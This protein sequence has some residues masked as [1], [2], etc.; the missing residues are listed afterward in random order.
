MKHIKEMPVFERPFKIPRQSESRFFVSN[1]RKTVCMSYFWT[2]AAKSICTSLLNRRDAPNIA[3]NKMATIP[4][5]SEK[6]RLFINLNTPPSIPSCI[7]IT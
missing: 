5:I 7:E 2:V 1:H 3:V 4:P 6:D